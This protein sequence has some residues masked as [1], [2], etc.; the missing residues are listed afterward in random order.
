MSGMSVPAIREGM[1]GITHM[2]VKLVKALGGIGE[3]R[4]GLS[5]A[6]NH[7]RAEQNAQRLERIARHT[8][9]SESIKAAAEARQIAKGAKTLD[10]VATVVAKTTEEENL[11]RR[12]AQTLRFQT[13]MASKIN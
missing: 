11:A 13:L 6:A 10:A 7:F 8:R 2:G 1:G 4:V 12:A 9:T 3:E 5:L